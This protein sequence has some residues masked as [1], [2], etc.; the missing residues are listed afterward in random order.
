MGTFTSAV[1]IPI[2]ELIIQFERY[3]LRDTPTGSTQPRSE[4]LFLE[5][6]AV[7]ER[8]PRRAALTVGT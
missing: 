7:Q 6:Q 3:Q 5:R 2:M 1:R 8:P 4:R